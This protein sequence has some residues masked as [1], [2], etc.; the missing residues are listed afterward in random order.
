MKEGDQSEILTSQVVGM[1]V[2]S[3]AEIKD[4]VVET[5]KSLNQLIQAQIRTEERQAA[6]RAWQKRVEIHQDKQDERIDRAIEI[7]GE[8]K[9][10]GNEAKGQ[11]LRNGMWINLGVAILT[12]VAI[13]IC[14][15]IVGA[16]FK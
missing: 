16:L 3:N 5:N 13:F 11:S 8:A 6:D 1:L 9:D 15:E 4:A 7:A 12:G 2:K 10:I 14:K